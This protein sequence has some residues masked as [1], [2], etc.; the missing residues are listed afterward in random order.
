MESLR[1]K[2]EQFDFNTQLPEVKKLLADASV[3]LTFWGSRAVTVN[4]YSG[5][6]YLDDLAKRVSCASCRYNNENFSARERYA[7]LKISDKL[8][9][10][11]TNTDKALSKACP[12]TWIFNGFKE[13]YFPLLKKVLYSAKAPASA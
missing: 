1:A 12:L 5:F 6:I 3:K 7:G 11:Y 2:L 13:F 8:S 4:G 9:T 10:F